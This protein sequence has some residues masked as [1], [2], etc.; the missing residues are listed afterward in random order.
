[1]PAGVRVVGGV[2]GKIRNVAHKSTLSDA[3]AGALG[4][5]E[6]GIV[7][8]VRAG[9]VEAVKAKMP[10][11]T[12]VRTAGVDDA[13]AQSI[14]DAAELITK[15]IKQI[16]LRNGDK[17][18]LKAAIRPVV[19][20]L[21]PTFDESN[22]GC[23]SFADLLKKHNDQFRIERN[24]HAEVVRLLLKAGANVN[25]RH[26]DGWSALIWASAISRG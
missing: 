6:S 26:K 2:L 23:R 13:T 17:W 1:M 24:G 22:Y 5:D 20:R 7:A 16:S 19:K 8:L 15:A 3:L 11:A 4:P 25:E 12:K 18:V 21:D 14:K 10:R 9:D